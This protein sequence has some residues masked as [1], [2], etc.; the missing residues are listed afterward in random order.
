MDFSCCFAAGGLCS[1][2]AHTTEDI[3]TALKEFNE[4]EKI[5]PNF[6]DVHYYLGK[7]Y[8]LLQGNAGRAKNELK[9]YLELYPEAPEKDE[10]NTTIEKLDKI[11]KEKR[12][13]TISGLE[14]ITLHDG[15]YVRKRLPLKTVSTRIV[16]G[17]SPMLALQPGDK[18]VSVNDTEVGNHTLDEVISLMDKD[19]NV[20]IVHIKVIRGGS[21][22]NAVLEK[23]VSTNID[24]V[25]YL[26]EED[27]K[28]IVE[29]SAIPVIAVFWKTDDPACLR[30]KNDIS[31]ESYKTKNSV[32]IYLVNIDENV[33][34][35][36]EYNVTKIPTILFFKEGKLIGKIVDYQPNLFKEKTESINTT[37]EPFGL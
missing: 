24:N 22:F 8:S 25:S 3:E 6:P 13:S 30:Y 15:I 20:R 10:V 5:A 27:L 23:S 19:P 11:V 18:L 4:A 28:D 37:N 7:K 29:E 9:K 2:R 16:T 34:I 17:R 14:L 31:E 33:L 32:K 26:G 35:S 1:C 12:N 36:S 21:F